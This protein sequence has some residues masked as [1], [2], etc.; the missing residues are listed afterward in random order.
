MTRLAFVSQHNN[1]GR[2][3]DCVQAW[4]EKEKLQGL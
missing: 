2:S 1:I 4:V 3:P